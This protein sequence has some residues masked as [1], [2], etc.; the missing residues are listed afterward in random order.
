M[1]AKN[2]SVRCLSLN[3]ITPNQVGLERILAIANRF[4][5]QQPQFIVRE[6]I[7][8]LPYAPKQRSELL[9][10]MPPTIPEPLSIEARP[11]EALQWATDRYLPYRRWEIVVKRAP[12]GERLSDEIAASFEDWM[13]LHYPNLKVDAVD[14][15]YLNY[16]VA[17]LVM[18]LCQQHPVLWVVVD[19]LG[20]LDH[21][22]L[23]QYLKES[24]NFVE[25]T[26]IEPRFSIL[27]T[28]TEYAKWSLYSQLPCNDSD[29]QQDMSKVF[30]KLG[31]G[32]RYT[33]L[34]DNRLYEDLHQ[35]KHKL[36]CLDTEQ[37]DKLY[38]SERDLD[39]LHSLNAKMYLNELPIR[40]ATV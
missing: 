34:R 25:Q 28:K 4:L 7:E 18:Q 15:S 40:L 17:Y 10:L 2:L 21:I 1:G 35:S 37:L 32:A 31:I 3:Q 29:W 9:S 23:L 36:Y 38:H 24:T 26:S 27:P 30:P 14:N 33:D 12:I 19:G 20:W 13:L 11:E 8:K 6:Q 22:Q 5:T 16:N 39:S